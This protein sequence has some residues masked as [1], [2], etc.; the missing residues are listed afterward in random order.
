MKI[1]GFLTLL[2][3]SLSAVAQEQ[4][5]YQFLRFP[6]STHNAALGGTHISLVEDD[7]ML[8]LDNPALLAGIGGKTLSASYMT[9][10]SGTKHLGAAYAFPVG[11]RHTFGISA[12]YMDYGTM[13][14]T[15]AQGNKLGTF[16]A[17]DMVIGGRYS[18]LLTD[19]WSGGAALKMLYSRLGD[20]SAVALAVDVGANYYDEAIGTSF[21]VALKNIGVQLKS[22]NDT[23]EDELPFDLQMG[24]TH[25]LANAPL[26]F[27]LTMVDLTRWS[28]DYYYKT[29][30]TRKDNFAKKLLNHCIVGVDV[31]ASDNLTFSAGYNV[32]R[33][34]ELKAAGAGHGAGLSLG[35]GLLVDKVKFGVAFAKYHVAA[36]SLLFNV[37][38]NF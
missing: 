28:S 24:V 9:Y 33:A 4:V 5:A 16:T 2:L 1:I 25:Q 29:D 38:Y 22:F 19:Y 18:Y 31:L 36:S 37:S 14:E 12:Q 11:E 27:S 32:R 8:S 13:D 21:S 3:A 10:I 17:K 35:A 34:R 15:D 26:R 7:A 20:F 23:S 30:A 6:L